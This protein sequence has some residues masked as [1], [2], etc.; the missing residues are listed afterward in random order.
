MTTAIYK[1]LRPAE[2]DALQQNQV[3]E[4]S[5]DDIRDGFIHLSTQQQVAGTLAKHFAGAGTLI[6]ITLEPEDLGADLKW[7]PSRG[8][9]LFPHLYATLKLADVK[10]VQTLSSDGS[11]TA[12][13]PDG[14]PNA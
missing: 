7:E 2:W 11:N 5:P 4:G 13:L 14:W 8:G 1:I 3:F 9:A 12:Q 6:L 10:Q